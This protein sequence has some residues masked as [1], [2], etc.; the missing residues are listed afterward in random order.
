MEYSLRKAKNEKPIHFSGQMM[1]LGLNIFGD[2]HFDPK[3]YIASLVA[4]VPPFKLGGGN[5]RFIGNG[6]ANAIAVFSQ[7]AQ[8]HTGSDAELIHFDEGTMLPNTISTEYLINHLPEARLNFTGRARMFDIVAN[9]TSILDETSLKFEL[10]GKPFKGHFDSDI[11]VTLDHE[12]NLKNGDGAMMAMTLTHDKA[13]KT[14][15]STMN[16]FLIRWVN[17]I[18]TSVDDMSSMKERV[19]LKKLEKLEELKHIGECQRFEV[20][21]DKPTIECIEF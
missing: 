14:L 9:V 6:D 19:T 4:Q 15:T 5:L 3:T 20:C 18:L 21:K 12:G 2:I 8:G 17:Q 10:N 1:F 16:R 11:V 7:K 13:I